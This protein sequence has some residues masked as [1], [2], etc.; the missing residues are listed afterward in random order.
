[1]QLV[2][3]VEALRPG[4][5][6]RVDVVP[7]SDVGGALNRKNVATLGVGYFS[8]RGM[9]GGGKKGNEMAVMRIAEDAGSWNCRLPPRR[10]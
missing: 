6:E 8:R 10:W 5:G 2:Q 3:E 1:M 7:G 9:A 4:P